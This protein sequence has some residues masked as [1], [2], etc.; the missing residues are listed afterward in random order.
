LSALGEQ[1]DVIARR[2][3]AQNFIRLVAD[4]LRRL[5][6]TNTERC[7]LASQL[8]NGQDATCCLATNETGATAESTLMSIHETW[9]EI[10]NTPCSS[11]TSPSMSSRIPTIL[12]TCRWYQCGKLRAWREPVLRRRS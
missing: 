3:P 12:H 9:F 2:K 7:S 10:R 11:A 1:H 6:S 8:T 4:F 5:R